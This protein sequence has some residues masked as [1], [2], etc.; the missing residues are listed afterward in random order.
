MGGL[1]RRRVADEKFSEIELEVLRVSSPRSEIE[2]SP[3][4]EF[5]SVVPTLTPSLSHTH[6]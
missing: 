3:I 4:T 6:S 2:K 1:G 5:V